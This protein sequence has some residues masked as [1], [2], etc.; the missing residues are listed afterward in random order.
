VN[1]RGTDRFWDLSSQLPAEAKTAAREAFRVFRENPAHPGLRLKRLRG[2][3]RAWLVR[4]TRDYRAVA[5]R[6][7]DNWTWV[8]IGIHREFDR[9]FAA[10]RPA[11][12][13]CSENLWG[14]AA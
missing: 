10:W 7:W 11:L 2:D 13:D 9:V 12:I 8:R 5:F 3:P 1:S 4:I 6:L 14:N